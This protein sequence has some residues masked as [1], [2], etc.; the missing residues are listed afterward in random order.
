VICEQYNSADATAKRTLKLPKEF[1]FSPWEIRKFVLAYP[2]GKHLIDY[3]VA[4]AIYSALSQPV[5]TPV[6]W[7]E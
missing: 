6:F 7:G 1:S 5:T 4:K 3:R 2:H